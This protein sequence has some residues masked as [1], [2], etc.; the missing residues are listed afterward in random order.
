MASNKY[1]LQDALRRQLRK[2]E[3]RPT[4]ESEKL[5]FSDLKALLDTLEGQELVDAL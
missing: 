2:S 1:T 5:L 4:K 3:K